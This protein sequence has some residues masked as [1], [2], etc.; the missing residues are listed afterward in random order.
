MEIMSSTTEIPAI[1]RPTRS[2]KRLNVVKLLLMGPANAGKS[3]LG[4]KLAEVFNYNKRKNTSNFDSNGES[5]LPTPGIDFYTVK[6][7]EDSHSYVLW[8]LGGQEHYQ[9]LWNIWWKGA[10]GA[11]V[12][13]DSTTMM[14][15]YLTKV[16]KIIE[17]IRGT[18]SLP[19]LVCLNKLD[20]SICNK[21]VLKNISDY[22]DVE[23]EKIIPVSAVTGLNVKNALYFLKE[24]SNC[25]NSL[26]L[27]LKTVLVYKKI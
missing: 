16:R 17:L 12:V 11:F 26:I 9:P 13:I 6:M 2:L 19:F 5:Y 3:K 14:E 24:L 18:L 22:L 21:T 15:S 1:N 27:L 20:L 23:E 8:E 7:Q 25:L 4:K 10:K